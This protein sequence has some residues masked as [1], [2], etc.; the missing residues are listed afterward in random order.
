MFLGFKKLFAQLTKI[1]SFCQT[2]SL[3]QMGIFLTALLV[4]SCVVSQSH[5]LRRMQSFLTR[6]VSSLG[7]PR[8]G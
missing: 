8:T 4:K 2:E 1:Q 6:D 5:L 7:G 3:S